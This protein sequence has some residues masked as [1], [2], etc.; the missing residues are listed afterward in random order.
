M[1]NLNASIGMREYLFK[2]YDL[3]EICVCTSVWP[4][5]RNK[6][7]THTANGDVNKIIGNECVCVYF[8]LI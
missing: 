6:I 2:I 8:I 4:T 5:V 7:N 3:Y 1:R